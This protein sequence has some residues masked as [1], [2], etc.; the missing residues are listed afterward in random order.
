ML[1]ARNNAVRPPKRKFIVAYLAMNRGKVR[2]VLECANPDRALSVRSTSGP[3]LCDLRGLGN[4]LWDWCYG[5][6]SGVK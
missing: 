2:K 6:D 3:N 5:G 1:I 4:Q